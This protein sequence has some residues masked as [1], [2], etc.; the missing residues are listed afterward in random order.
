MS[1]TGD[2]R[3]FA[4][5]TGIRMDQ[6]HRKVI[7]DLNS[8]LVKVCP[9]DTGYARSNFFV[10]M[11]RVGS[12]SQDGISKNGSASIERAMKFASTAKAGGIVYITNNVPYILPIIEYG[13]SGQ[14]AS[15][16]VTRI[17]ARWQEIVNGAV[18]ATQAGRVE[19]GRGL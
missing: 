10:G 5:N 4:H 19:F 6:V 8:D 16:G 2:L 11:N 15:G 7:I 17:V 3:S 14:C 13:H 9:V 12:V 1:F 18:R